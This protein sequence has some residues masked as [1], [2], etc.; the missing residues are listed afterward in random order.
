M[1]FGASGVGLYSF[2]GVGALYVKIE[3]LTLGKKLCH[4]S[5]QMLCILSSL[6]L[7]E[8][9]VVVPWSHRNYSHAPKRRSLMGSSLLR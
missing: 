4:T 8:V 3:E 2:L 5:T 6:E 1:G 7:W 9:V